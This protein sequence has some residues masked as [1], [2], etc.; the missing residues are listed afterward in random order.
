MNTTTPAAPA[1]TTPPAAPKLQRLEK[2]SYTH[3]AMVDLILTEPTVSPSEL[4]QIF[5][6]SVGWISRILASDSF[7]S[8][9]AERKS[10]QIDP[11]VAATMDERLRGIAIHSLEIISEKLQAEESAAYAIDALG[12]AAMGLGLGGRK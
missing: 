2:L 7:Q 5:N 12:L 6:Y 10:H 1:A 9:L 11:M 3:E 8:R 4:A